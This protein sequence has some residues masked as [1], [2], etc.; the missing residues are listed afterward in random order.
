MI[1]DGKFDRISETSGKIKKKMKNSKQNY[2]ALKSDV[3]SVKSNMEEVFK[4]ESNELRESM[5]E[6]I[7]VLKEERQ[8]LKGDVAEILRILSSHAV[9]P[10][11]PS[12]TD[13]EFTSQDTINASI[14]RLDGVLEGMFVISNFQELF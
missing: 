10:G 5:Q 3:I 9:L 12:D 2:E 1:L 14:P 6:D 7:R 4:K 11:Y 13:S 8:E